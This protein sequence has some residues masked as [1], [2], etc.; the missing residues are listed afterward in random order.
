MHAVQGESLTILAPKGRNANSTIQRAFVEFQEDDNPT[1]VQSRARR[2]RVSLAY[3]T[4]ELTRCC[5]CSIVQ[6]GPLYLLRFRPR[7]EYHAPGRASARVSGLHE[8]T[9]LYR[10]HQRTSSRTTSRRTG[11]LDHVEYYK[12]TTPTHTHVGPEE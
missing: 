1:K 5:C 4:N 3:I 10:I 6:Q 12:F 9:R 8:L 11:Y 7:K 2:R